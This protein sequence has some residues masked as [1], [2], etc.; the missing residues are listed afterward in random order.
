MRSVILLIITMAYWL[1]GSAA[2][3]MVLVGGATGHQGNAVVDELLE[4]GYTVRCLTRKPEGRKALRIAG[5]CAELVQGDYSDPA[6]LDAAMK[7]VN[8]V[9]FYSG[10]SRNEVAEGNNVITAAK[11][12]GIE[13]LVYSSGAAAE[14][15]KGI[16]GS[17]KMQVEIDLIASGVPYTVLRP[18]AFMENF[19][20]QQ[21]RILAK[22][23]A[24]SRGPDRILAFISIRDIGFFVGEAFDHPDI[25]L[26]RAE[27]IA[28]DR[29][30][31]REYVDTF[32][33]VVGTEIVYTRMPVEEYLATLPK[34]I[35][36]LFQWY[37]QVGY[38]ADVDTLRSSYPGLITLNGYLVA[39]GWQ[40]VGR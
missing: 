18:V 21:Q 15:G 28:G 32:S 13:H 36:P 27:N 8:K 30:T 31:V 35:R 23:I 16:A 12:A 1:A 20:G 22:G 4:R 10:Y 2:A 29:M 26:D 17:P 14:P 34:P 7:G 5:R 40:D 25:W 39:T 3:E 37:D 6:S 38:D 19:D 11:Q 24:E 9:F 33:Q